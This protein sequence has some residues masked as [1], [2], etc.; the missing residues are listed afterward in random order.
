MTASRAPTAG[1]AETSEQRGRRTAQR[2]EPDRPAGDRAEPSDCA[3]P[4]PAGYNSRPMKSD[5][6]RAADVLWIWAG[7]ALLVAVGVGTYLNTFSNPFIFDDLSFI[8]DNPNIRSLWPIGRAASAPAGTGASGRPLV[9]LSLAINYAF[10]GL[11]V[12]GYHCFNVGAHVLAG[13]TLLGVVRRTLQG[14]TLAGRFGSAA[15]PLSLTTALLWVVHPLATDALNHVIYRNE[16]LMGLFYLLTLYC[17]VRGTMSPRPRAWHVLAVVCCAAGMASK[18]PMVSAP[19]MVLLLDRWFYAGSFAA[20]LKPRWPLY[21]GL[22]ATWLLLAALVATGSRG[23]SVGFRGVTVTSYEYALTQLSVIAHYLKLAVWPAPLVL[24]YLDWPVVHS[25]TEPGWSALIVPSALMLTAVALVRWPRLGWLGLAFFAILAPSSS[26]IPIGAEIAAEHRM[27]LPLASCVVLVVLAGW[28]VLW[29]LRGTLRL[30]PWALRGGTF[31]LVAGVA[32]VLSVATVRRNTDYRTEQAIWEDT[33]RKRPAN[34]RAHVALGSIAARSGRHVEAL[35]YY[36]RALALGPREA[37]AHGYLATTLEA[38]GRV[39]EALAAYRRVVELAPQRASAHY[40][41]GAALDRLGRLDE[42]R[43]HYEEAVRRDPA[44]FRAHTNLGVLLA[45]TGR[46]SEAAEHLRRAL[47]LDPTQSRIHANLGSVLAEQGRD[48]EA[49]HHFRAALERDPQDEAA[50]QNL[51]LIL[52]RQGRAD[53][54]ITTYADLLR[55]NPRNAVACFNLGL[56][57]AAKDR[58]PEAI[59]SYRQAL[60]VRPDWPSALSELALLLATTSDPALRDVPEAVRLAQVACE[61]TR[62]LDPAALATLARAYHAAGRHEEAAQ[63][64]TAAVGRAQALG[65]AGLAAEYAALS[66]SWQRRDSGGVES[67]DR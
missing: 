44:D 52:T 24:D 3:A 13:L 28:R 17:F 34:P 10:G 23:E 8:V 63:T 18:E 48:A 36:Q 65:R 5:T 43:P 33:V 2:H 58:P 45:R 35:V 41:L 30:P 56:A 9:A 27:Y 40:N 47:E 6:K 25:L 37:I 7:A 53:E 39:E 54:V 15:T 60:E 59:R 50:H 64:I 29:T 31:A 12:W 51:A 14:P 21:V 4:V 61:R 67:P 49:L 38:L 46:L 16:V 1:L 42:A 66:D 57:Y 62:R 20:A 19:L 22:A 26:I 11:N 55:R 32:G